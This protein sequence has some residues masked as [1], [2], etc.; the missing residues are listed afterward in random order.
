MLLTGTGQC[1]FGLA[2][3]PCRFARTRSG[4]LCAHNPQ[5]P[6]SFNGYCECVAEPRRLNGSALEPEW[7]DYLDPRELRRSRLAR[8]GRRRRTGSPARDACRFRCTDHCVPAYLAALPVSRGESARSSSAARNLGSPG[9]R[10]SP[11]RSRARSRA[12]SWRSR[13]TSG[14]PGSW[15][16]RARFEVPSRSG[17]RFGCIACFLRRG[18]HDGTP[19]NLPGR[20]ASAT[21]SA[22]SGAAVR[23]RCHGG[24]RRAVHVAVLEPTFWIG[25]RFFIAVGFYGLQRFVW[26]FFKPYGT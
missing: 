10:G 9:S 8:G 5:S 22:R 23:E 17:S 21:A 1:T 6:A 12:P 20:M 15:Y 16:A 18:I 24:V 14:S 13:C 19:R 26:E 7:G 2:F 3:R 11:A 4:P 25:Q